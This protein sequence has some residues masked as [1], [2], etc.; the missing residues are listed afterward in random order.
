MTKVAVGYT[1]PG[2]LAEY[3]LIT[4]EILAADCLLPVPDANLP[5]FAA[6][7]A[8]PISCAISAQDRHVH[9][10]QASPSARRI[11]S[12]G[13]LRNGITMII[14]AGPMG[15]MHAEVALRF[16]L[17]H[18]II[19]DISEQRLGWIKEV[20]AKR[21]EKAGTELHAVLSAESR[22][23]LQKLSKGMGADDI[24]VAVGNAEVQTEAQQ[25]LARGGVLDLFAGLKKGEHLIQ[26]DT[27][28]VHYDDI[29]VVGSSGGSPADIA[30]ALRMIASGEIDV[31]RHM[32]IVGSLDQLPRAL[33]MVKNTETDGKIVLYPHIR[34]TD[35]IAA[36]GWRQEDELRFLQERASTL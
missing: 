26:L 2:H 3:T 28:R 29:K 34:Q 35:L 33:Q 18:L 19:V 17:R 23:L 13:L 30:E 15:R 21:A 1:L 27:V 32:T 16:Q 20:L 12:L 5:A 24:I 9:I 11:P 31:G 14:G 4:E 6:A 36:K 7:L 25:W 10:S 8:E 22:E